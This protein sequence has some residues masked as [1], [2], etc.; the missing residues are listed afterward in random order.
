MAQIVGTNTYSRMVE[1]KLRQESIFARLFNNR[2]E[3]TAGGVQ[4]PVREEAA[5]SEYNIANGASLAAPA[6]TYIPIVLDKD[7]AVNELIDGFVSA[8]VSDN[9]IAERLDSAGFALADQVDVALATLL[10]TSGT[11][12]SSTT[13]L[14]KTTVY[15]AIIDAVQTAKALKIK[16]REMWI[17]VDNATYGL[18]LQCSEFIQATGNVAELGNGYV[19]KLAGIPVYETANLPAKT[20]FVVGN[21]VFCHYVDAWKV[22]P[23]VKD[24][25]DGKHIGSSAVQGRIVYGHTISKPTTVIV[26][27]K[28]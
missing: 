10:A 2:N 17:A 19:G 26:K 20:E 5:V 25:A 9:M 24:L 21:N 14:T 8:A 27:K 16:P 12:L 15:G 7:Y 23:E 3:Q 22:V 28:A 4:I 13:A 11:A 1:A 18:L 6:T